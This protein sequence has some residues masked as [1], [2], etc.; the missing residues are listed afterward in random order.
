MSL[1]EVNQ[2]VGWLGEWTQNWK[3][4]LSVRPKLLPLFKCDP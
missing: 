2:I 4:L 3:T 1:S